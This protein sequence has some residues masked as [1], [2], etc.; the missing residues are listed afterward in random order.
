MEL[1]WWAP[2][3]GKGSGGDGEEPAFW[4][5]FEQVRPVMTGPIISPFIAGLP[6]A[7]LH[8]H[9]EGSLEPETMLSLAARNGVRLP[10]VNATQLRC[11]YQ[12]ADL[13]AFLDLYYLGLTVLQTGADFYE[14]TAV[15][16]ARAARDNV[17]HAEVFI[18]P[19]AHLR[20]GIAI[21]PVI[22][23]ILAAIDDARDRHGITGGLIVSIQR[24]FDESDALV[25]I[26][27]V[28]PWRDRI[29]GLGMGGAEIGNP[30]SKFR[31]AYDVVR[32]ECGWHTMAHAGEEGG[33]DYVRDALHTLQCERIDHGVRCEADPNLVGEL[34]DRGTPLT[35]CPLSNCML[36]VF[37]DLASHNIRR[38]HEAGV[39]VTVNSDD[40][41]YFD[42][43]VNANFAAI[44]EK[45][46]M[47]DYALW[48][49]A[50]NSFTAAFLPDDLRGRYLVEL[51]QHKP[52]PAR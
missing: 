35:V 48:E 25:M 17:R 26:E 34:A 4:R 27:A 42:G 13:Q 20:R 44:Q 8:M 37:P 33:A 49:M 19:Q 28:K 43:Y 30:P 23:N 31:R 12:F 21:E 3:P 32:G 7:E 15:Y 51:E 5:K 39:C 9:L 10:Y 41:P 52:A 14:M 1:F 24:Q 22:E 18:S 40:P 50:H 11:A 45:L 16:F 29:I 38:L 36:N 46:G 2:P 47:S 6:K